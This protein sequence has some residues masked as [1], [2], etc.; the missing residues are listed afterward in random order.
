MMTDD[1]LYGVVAL[2]HE[3]NLSFDEALDMD[4][5]VSMVWQAYFARRNAEASTRRGK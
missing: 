5:R 3:L 1:H 4:Y 2:A